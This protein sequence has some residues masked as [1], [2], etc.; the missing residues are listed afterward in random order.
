[1]NHL[2]L[3]GGWA[4]AV[5]VYALIHAYVL[6]QEWAKQSLEDDGLISYV[7]MGLIILAL[8]TTLLIAKNSPSEYRRSI[9]ILAYVILIYLLREADFHRLFT[10]EHVTRG[11]FYLDPSIS[12][13]QKIA[14]GTPLLLLF[15]A[16]FYLLYRYTGLLIR[17]I[18]K[19][20]SW[21]LAV[22]LWAIA[23]F[24][25]QVVDRSSLNRGAFGFA[26]E[27]LLELAAAGYM[28]LA[29]YIARRSYS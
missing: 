16:I 4:I 26:L 3:L 28:L 5:S 9:Y 17:H 29:A 10:P 27:E 14:G 6:P 23:I 22:V 7:T 19:G 12:I 8:G 13:T 20:H 21:A 1:M 24:L 15:A 11:K 2:R 18:I 25:S